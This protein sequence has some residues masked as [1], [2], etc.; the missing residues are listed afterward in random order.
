MRV[1]VKAEPYVTV[2]EYEE[3]RRPVS[4]WKIEYSRPDDPFVWIYREDAKGQREYLSG[5]AGRIPAALANEI[6]PLLNSRRS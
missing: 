3:S 2:F 5:T 1:P 4:E 6:L